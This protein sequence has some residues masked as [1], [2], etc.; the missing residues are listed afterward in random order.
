MLL[1]G[2]LCLSQLAQEGRLE[3]TKILVYLYGSVAETL[4]TYYSLQLKI[5]LNRPYS[6]IPSLRCLTSSFRVA[7]LFFCPKKLQF[8]KCCQFFV[9]SFLF[10]NL[11]KIFNYGFTNYKHAAFR[12]TP[13][14]FMVRY[15][16]T[17]KPKTIR[18]IFN[19]VWKINMCVAKKV[20]DLWE[21]GDQRRSRLVGRA[22]CD[23][24]GKKVF[25]R[26]FN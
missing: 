3:Y 24:F 17:A 2:G 16:C 10:Y 23:D 8:W 25:S 9:I 11:H 5:F 1:R 12:Q 21:D 20:V 19:R 26:F 18:Y 15:I 4:Y 22:W 7:A 6:N 13:Q 14:K